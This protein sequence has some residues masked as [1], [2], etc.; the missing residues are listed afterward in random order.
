M[1]NKAYVDLMPHKL[2]I[3]K[4]CR[5][6]SD[7]NVSLNMAPL[8]VDGITLEDGDRVL[9]NG[10]T[11]KK[12]NG[13]YTVITKGTGNDG[14]WE[15][16]EDVDEDDEI[17]A[18]MFAFVTEGETHEDTG[19]VVI[20]NNP[21]DLGTHDIEFAQFSGIGMV[22][23][24]NG[25]YQNGTSLHVGL[26]DNSLE[27]EE[28]Q[29]K[30]NLKD[31]SII[32]GAE[33]LEL[34]YKSAYFRVESSNLEIF[35]PDQD[36]SGQFLIS[37]DQGMVSFVSASGDMEFDDT[38]AVTVQFSDSLLESTGS[39]IRLVPSPDGQVLVGQTDD[40]SQWKTLTGDGTIF[41]DGSSLV[42]K[43]IKDVISFENYIREIPEG[44]IDGTN[45]DFALSEIP[46]ENSE[47]IFLNGV[48][49]D[50]YDNTEEVGDYDI[51]GKNFS[52]LEAPE[53]GSYLSA[54][55]LRPYS[56]IDYKEYV[57]D[58]GGED[59]NLYYPMDDSSSTMTDQSGT[60]ILT[61]GVYPEDA[62][63]SQD[64]LA[65]GL[66][67]GA[68][69][70][71]S[72]L[73]YTVTRNA[74]T[75]KLHSGE[76]TVLFWCRFNSTPNSYMPL[77]ITHAGASA[78][79]GI[80]ILH[81]NRIG[82]LGVPSG[83]RSLRFEAYRGTFGTSVYGGSS[84]F[85]QQLFNPDNSNYESDVRFIA[86]TMGNDVMRVYVN[87]QQ[88]GSSSRTHSFNT[89]NHTNTLMQGGGYTTMQHLAHVSR[90]LTASEI[91]FLYQRGIGE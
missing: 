52:F 24:G 78:N 90:V 2:E 88:I 6:L 25:I 40:E 4:S 68:I 38:G 86:I 63:F 11:D 45:T 82:V 60:G 39:G 67:S 80:G 58:I 15:R 66:S 72:N 48:L 49:Q 22:Q 26:A 59:L 16:A 37:D 84:F 57:W 71:P 9:V 51:S 62:L 3:K 41:F 36:P 50:K 73:R 83:Q 81:D 27:F 76:G 8:A 61:N 85:A 44:D 7:Q 70:F 32:V 31:Q 46:L 65:D 10:Q 69:T 56:R 47:M 79:V 43:V 18:G 23:V 29:L 55:Y 33:G 91:A 17:N 54:T 75:N 64:P 30:V 5:A 28:G 13:I 42:F 53:V 14:V 74:E 19:W 77:V 20:T 34:S 21:I 12:E 1:A 35:N 89:G 87:G